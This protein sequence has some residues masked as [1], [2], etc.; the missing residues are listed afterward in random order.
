MARRCR[1]ATVKGTYLFAY[2]GFEIKE[3]DRVPFAVAGREVRD[4]NG[5]IKEGDY[6]ANFNGEIFTNVPF[7]SEYTVNPDCTGTNTFPDDGSQYDMFIDPDGREF[8][9]VQTKPKRFV[10]SWTTKRVED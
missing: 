10:T 3:G 2:E 8:R 6:S 9:V 1:L 5:N 7:S 4:G